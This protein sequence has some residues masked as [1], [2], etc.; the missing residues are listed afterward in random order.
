MPAK[1]PFYKKMKKLPM[2]PIKVKVFDLSLD[3]PERVT[4]AQTFESLD[5]TAQYLEIKNITHLRTFLEPN[6]EGIFKRFFSK[7]HNKHFAL[8]RCKS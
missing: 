6:E 5:K 1:I 4:K 3:K 2:Q 7:K 8:R